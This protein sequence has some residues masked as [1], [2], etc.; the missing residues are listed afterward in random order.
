MS[1]T[2]DRIRRTNEP[3]SDSP[4]ACCASRIAPRTRPH[5]RHELDRRQHD[6]RDPVARPARDERFEHVVGER[7]EQERHRREE[8]DEHPP[9]RDE[10]ERQPLTRDRERPERHQHVLR[11]REEQA[12]DDDD[13]EQQNGRD[14]HR[15]EQRPEQPGCPGRDE[16]RRPRGRAGPAAAAGTPPG[17]RDRAPGAW[18]AGCAG[19]ASWSPRRNSRLPRTSLVSRPRRPRRSRRSGSLLRP[20]PR[21]GCT[22]SGR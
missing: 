20:W 19:G 13:R 22:S 3:S 10:P 12:V 14:A 5:P 11:R 2:S 8:R 16:D 6:E 7:R 18:S 17:G 9:R 21:R 1:G 4:R 15:A